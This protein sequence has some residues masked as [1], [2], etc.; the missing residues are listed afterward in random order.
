MAGPIVRYHTI[1][2]RL[3][4]RYVTRAG[5]AEGIRRF[6]IGLGKKVL[7]ADTLAVPAD[8]V[9]ALPAEELTAN[10]SWLGVICFTLQIY[11]D[12]SGYSDMALGL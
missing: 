6:I 11:F 10:L 2:A 9:F 7:S 8:A 5:L 1:A 3:T 12:F 4:R